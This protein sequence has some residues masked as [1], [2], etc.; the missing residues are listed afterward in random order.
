MF[1]RSGSHSAPTAHGRPVEREDTALRRLVDVA[2]RLG[3]ERLGR[4]LLHHL[5]A[6]LRSQYASLLA[7]NL[8]GTGQPKPGSESVTKSLRRS[9]WITG[10]HT[11]LVSGT[12]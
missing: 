12:P 3:G 8:A 1:F 7:S 10:R 9:R 5:L 4:E 2:C 6:D 11:R